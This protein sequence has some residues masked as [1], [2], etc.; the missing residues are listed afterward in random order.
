MSTVIY[1][2]LDLSKIAQCP[3]SVKTSWFKCDHCDNL[4]VVLFNKEGNPFAVTLF[5]VDMLVDMWQ[6]VNSVVV[7][8]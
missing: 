3:V 2:A 5:D 6:M 4:H 1:E 7:K 8:Q